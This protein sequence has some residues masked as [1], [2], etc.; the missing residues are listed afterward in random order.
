MLNGGHVCVPNKSCGSWNVFL[1]KNFIQFQNIYIAAG[2][3]SEN[4]PEKTPNGS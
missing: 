4:A 3:V 1:C 2:H